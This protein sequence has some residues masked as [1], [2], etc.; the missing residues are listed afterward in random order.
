[1]ACCH[2]R[3]MCDVLQAEKVFSEL[4]TL[5]PHHIDGMETYSTTLWHLSKEVQLS[6]LAQELTQT[7]KTAPQVRN[8]RKFI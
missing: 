6:V 5:E 2:D 7:D 1:M 3:T 8:A 4:R